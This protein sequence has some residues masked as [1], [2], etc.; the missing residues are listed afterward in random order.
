MNHELQV[1]VTV[2]LLVVAAMLA[3]ISDVVR[4][5]ALRRAEIASEVPAIPEPAQ[6]VA[7]HTLVPDIPAPQVSNGRSSRLAA[8]LKE[9]RRSL[10]PAAMAAIERGSKLA[11]KGPAKVEPAKQL[12][13]VG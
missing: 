2:T 11:R 10:S 5:R 8:S 3:V 9:K 1:V 7:R 12:Q 4:I 13:K 6:T